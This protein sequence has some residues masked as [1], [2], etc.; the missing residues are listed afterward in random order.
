MRGFIARNLP[1]VLY[2][3]I[4]HEPKPVHRLNPCIPSAVSEVIRK[5]MARN[6]D[7]RYASVAAFGDRL[8]A[9]T[10]RNDRAPGEK[11]NAQVGA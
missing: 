8:R 4:H 1:A 9:V 7:R 6:P 5:A 2:R 10:R 3:I 11:R